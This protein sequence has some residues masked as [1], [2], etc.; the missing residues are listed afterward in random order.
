M[1]LV[2]FWLFSIFD[3]LSSNSLNWYCIMNSPHP[4]TK[5]TSRVVLIYIYIAASI[6]ASDW[7]GGSPIAGLTATA[8]VV[9]SIE[10]DGASLSLKK[11]RARSK[12]FSEGSG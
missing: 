3:I 1:D 4:K 10:A 11:R 2:M 7:G 5:M 8:M 12:K 6:K 9:L